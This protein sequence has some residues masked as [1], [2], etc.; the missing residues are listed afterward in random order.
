M[1]TKISSEIDEEHLYQEAYKLLRNRQSTKQIE[2]ALVA[3]GAG[4]AS[5]SQIVQGVI[6]ARDAAKYGDL[7]Y[8]VWVRYVIANPFE[9]GF[10]I[11][12]LSIVSV[13]FALAAAV[14]GL[15]LFP[16]GTYPRIVLAGPGIISGLVFF[17]VFSGIVYLRYRAVRRRY[18]K[19]TR[20]SDHRVPEKQLLETA[21]L[22]GLRKMSESTKR[23][24][25]TGFKHGNWTKTN[26]DLVEAIMK[27]MTHPQVGIEKIQVILAGSVN[28][29]A[30]NES[31]RTVLSIANYHEAS[32]AVRALLIKAGAK[33]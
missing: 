32:S 12:L 8:M 30:I 15:L 25:R 33:E 31:G 11:G 20:T 5:A 14:M 13:V 19:T 28:I 10:L 26:N 7:G 18:R 23:R 24:V 2:S 22:I 16:P 9:S 29:N 6:E 27:S 21:E 3:S 4:P 1:A 17:L